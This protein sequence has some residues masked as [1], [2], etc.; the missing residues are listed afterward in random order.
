MTLTRSNDIFTVEFSVFDA[1]PFDI[2]QAEF[3]FFDGARNPVPVDNR[4]V[5]LKPLID[6]LIANRKLFRGQSFTIQQDYSNAT[7]HPETAGVRVTVKGRNLSQDSAE[8]R[9]IHTSSALVIA[10]SFRHAQ[11]TSLIL[12]SLKLVPSIHKHAPRAL[13]NSTR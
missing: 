1:D 5:N 10:Q 8:S 3:D 12:S 7:K 9:G 4:V 13:A 6:G 11:A 2:L